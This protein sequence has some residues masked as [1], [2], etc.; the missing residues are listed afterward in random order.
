MPPDEP[1]LEPAA[2]ADTAPTPPIEPTPT[3]EPTAPADLGDNGK[4][5]LD[6]ERAARKALERELAELRPLADDARKAAEARK[7][8]EQKLAEKLEA[9]TAAQSTA[10]AELA[11]YKA[12]LAAMPAGFDPAELPKVLKRLTGATPEELE[13]DA[14]ELFAL[15]APAPTSTT[16]Q[17]PGQ[18]TPVEALRP[19]A[20]PPGAEP[21]LAD[22]IRAAEQAGNTR[23][24][25][26]L[27]SAQLAELS[28]QAAAGT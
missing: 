6:A 5:A 7:T 13:S 25:M 20:L 15:F 1:T 22:Q 19:G 8:A 16:P 18:R 11:R 12:A 23:E 3:P 9:A 28:R 21:T 2:A 24:S 14:A 10:E 26:R 4:K 17:A 27:K